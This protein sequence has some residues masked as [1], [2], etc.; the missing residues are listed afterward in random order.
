MTK[1]QMINAGDFFNIDLVVD[2]DRAE[3]E[4]AENDN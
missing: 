4:F 3:K 2:T 1:Q